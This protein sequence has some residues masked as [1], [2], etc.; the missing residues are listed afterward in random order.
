MIQTKSTNTKNHINNNKNFS[1]N[2]YQQSQKVKGNTIAQYL[3]TIKIPFFPEQSNHAILNTL[4]SNE[5]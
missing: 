1:T 3:G 4:I 2:I 5:R